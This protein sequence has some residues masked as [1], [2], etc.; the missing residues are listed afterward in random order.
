M[1]KDA[2]LLLLEKVLR[3]KEDGA[4]VSDM[5]MERRLNRN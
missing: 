2:I 3:M 4:G 1:I 5:D